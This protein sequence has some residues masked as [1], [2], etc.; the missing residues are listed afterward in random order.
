ML[1]RDPND[2]KDIFI[3]VRAGAGGDEAAIFAGDLAAHVH[4][5]S[6]RTARCSVELLSESENEAGG[7]KE[8]VFAVK[9]G[10]P[11]RLLQVR[12]R[13]PP[14]AARA[15][16]R[17][18]GARAHLDR[19][20]RRAAGGRRRRRRRGDQSER[21][22]GRHVQGLG[23]GRPARQQDRIGDP[24]HAR[25]RPASSSRARRSA[26]RCRTASARWT[27]CARNSPNASGA[28]R[29]KRCGSL[30]RSQVGTGDR[31]EKI[32]TYNY[33]QDRITDHRINQNFRKH[34]GDHGRRHGPFGDRTANGRA[35]AAAGRRNAGRVTVAEAL[36]E[37]AGASK[38]P[39][40]AGRLDAALLLEARDRCAPR[41]VHHATAMRALSR[42]KSAPFD[43]R[44]VERRLAGV[45]VAYVTGRRRLLR[46]RR[47]RST[48]GVL[49]PRPE[50]EHLVEAALAAAARGAE[51]AAGRI[52]DVGTGSG[53]IAIT[54]ACGAARCVRVFGDRHLARRDR[55]RAPERRAQRR[56][57]SRARFCTAIWRSRC[58]R[59]A[60][61]DALV[62]NLP[63]VPTA[64]IPLRPDP[65]G[66]EPRSRSTAAP[67]ASTLYRR[68]HRDAPGDPGA[69][70][71]DAL[72]SRARHD[73]TAGRPGR[74][75]VSRR[76]RGDRR[77]LRRF[78]AFSERCAAPK[79]RLCRSA[80][81]SIPS[82]R[83][84]SSLPAA[85]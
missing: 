79:G 50:T 52:A 56:V 73:R 25:A 82:W 66:F 33:P 70:R 17:A 1:P 55:R 18:A 85:S 39:A 29:K 13:R 28:K 38:R 5:L 77:R 64:A 59:F 65:V 74:G 4:A 32:R 34:Q 15:G 6:P 30:R 9:G 8:A 53:A 35:R 26:R 71:R 7:Y 22:R 68:L 60:P 14:R 20:G 78:A 37:T 10:E 45:P 19:D 41:A 75:G 27:C 44:A 16:H 49:V 31:S 48:N 69:G 67:T 58:A 47:S 72:R 12:V 36:R 62:A 80:K 24:H 42:P 51:R 40:A 83:S 21:S 43:A 76:T 23:R 63:Y 54:L 2:D 61:F 46:P 3:E 11:Y 57:R 84:L 81:R